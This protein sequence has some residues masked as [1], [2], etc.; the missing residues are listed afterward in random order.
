MEF[1]WTA[2]VQILCYLATHKSNRGGKSRQRAAGLLFIPFDRDIYTR[3]ARII[4]QL[5]AGDAH[6]PNAGIAKFALDNSFDLLAHGLSQTLPMVFCSALFHL[7]PLGKTN[8]NIRKWM[9]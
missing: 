4:G 7:N 5:H 9:E 3:R 6:Q 1:R 2:Q 8:E